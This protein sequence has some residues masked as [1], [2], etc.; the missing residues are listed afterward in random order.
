[1]PDEAV[2]GTDMSCF[3]E[4]CY[5]FNQPLTIP[6][7]VIS[8]AYTFYQCYNFNQ[9]INIPSS[10]VTLAQTFGGCNNFNQPIDIPNNITNMFGTFWNCS[11]FNQP[12]SIPDNVTNMAHI[13][14]NCNSFNQPINIPNKATDLSNAFQNCFNFNQPIIIPNGV[15][16]L[17]STFYQCYNFNQDIIIPGTVQNLAGIFV[18]CKNLRNVILEEGITTYADS[19]GQC[20]NGHFS[21]PNSIQ[22]VS[23][24]ASVAKICY[25]GPL[26]VNNWGAN[27]PFPHE[28]INY[29]IDK[30]PTC[31]EVGIGRNAVCRVCGKK[32]DTFNIP[33]IEHNYENGVCTI[34]GKE[35][36]YTCE[37]E[38]VEMDIE[39]TNKWVKTD[40]SY[41]WKTTNLTSNYWSAQFK[42]TVPT[43]TKYTISL[44]AIF[45]SMYFYGGTLNIV[46]DGSSVHAGQNLWDILNYQ[47]LTFT[48]PKG[49]HTL[50]VYVQRGTA[51]QTGAYEEG[52]AYIKLKPVEID[53]IL[54]ITPIEEQSIEIS[55]DVEIA[56][57]EYTIPYSYFN[58]ETDGNIN[59]LT[60][61]NNDNFEYFTLNS[62][63][64]DENNIIVNITPKDVEAGSENTEVLSITLSDGTY[65]ASTDVKFTVYKEKIVTNAYE[66]VSVSGASYGFTLNTSTGYYVSGNKGKSNSAAVCKLVFTSTTGKLILDCINYA[67]AGW[68]Y[69]IIS[70]LDTTL[71]T[72]YSVDSTNVYKTFKNSNSS[73]VQTVTYSGLD[74]EEHFI[75][76][77]FRKDSSDNKNNDTLQFKVR[78]E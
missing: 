16:N 24:L 60:I 56:S 65:S 43:E 4:F 10:V 40:E 2:Y 27:R 31:T 51:E 8:M 54:T 35:Q 21:I 48:I 46:L 52:C 29:T 33:T 20:N 71:G 22:S 6:N 49:E 58:K 44:K 19:V 32:F 11:N 64:L 78:F 14:W 25:D 28:K 42:I 9:P 77:K 47:D 50:S 23:G 18:G 76:I 62:I 7:N 74:T 73:S 26:P 5:N 13:F 45:E 17:Y 12:I 53:D 68:D 39:D 75:Y 67:E 61:T 38:A 72:T 66:V 63:S 1:M 41:E 55:D 70:N 57:Q 59:N 34:C 30:E 3:L 15:T 69:G 37:W 36:P